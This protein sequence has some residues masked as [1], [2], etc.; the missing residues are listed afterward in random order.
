MEKLLPVIIGVVALIIGFVVGKILSGNKAKEIED[1]AKKEADLLL[2]K[3]E[4]EAEALK[5][6]KALEAKEYFLK[7]RGEWDEEKVRRKQKHQEREN[8][9]RDKENGLKDRQKQA[10]IKAEENARKSKDL[11]KL[12]VNLTEQLN[13]LN[14]KKE[15]V[16]KQLTIEEVKQTEGL[17]HLTDEEAQEY[18][19][20]LEQ[21][22]NLMLQMWLEKEEKD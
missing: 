17:E 18:L 20:S 1:A 6:S 3:T 21:Y 8:Q 15:K 12:K 14:T 5:K 2:N 7:K 4:A 10:S 16:E 11:D 13:L 19:T 22:C 9:V